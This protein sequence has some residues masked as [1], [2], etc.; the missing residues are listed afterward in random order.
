M[1]GPPGIPGGGPRGPPPLIGI[2]ALPLPLMGGPPIM[3]SPHSSPPGPPITQK[4]KVT[5]KIKVSCLLEKFTGLVKKIC[6]S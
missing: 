4:T 5:Y 1:G 6:L 3:F 2:P